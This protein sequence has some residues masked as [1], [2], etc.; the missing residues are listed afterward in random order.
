MILEITNAVNFL[1]GSILFSFAAVILAVMII[2]LNNLFH[3]YWKPIKW[4]IFDPQD[5]HIVDHRVIEELKQS[6]EKQ[7]TDKKDIK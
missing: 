3:K 6:M 7:K 2:I 5:V 4:Q 1:I